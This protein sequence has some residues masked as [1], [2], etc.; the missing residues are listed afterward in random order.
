MAET[1]LRIALI[2]L[3]DDA[4]RVAFQL[5]SD[6][7]GIANPDHWGLFGGHIE[8]GETPEAG[9]IRE[10][11]EELSVRIDPA[12]M[13]P[14]PLPY[15]TGLPKD[16][17]SFHYVVADELD[18]TRLTEGERWAWLTREQIEAGEVD[19]KPIVAYHRE[20]LL[21]FLGTRDVTS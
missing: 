1:P 11:E 14:I 20:W 3:E 15:Q 17:Y 10:V 21:D 9:A 8:P 6:V 19:G 7:A 16:Y 4:A 13:R 12:K 2:V 18:H 5:R